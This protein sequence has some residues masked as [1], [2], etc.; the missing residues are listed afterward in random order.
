MEAYDTL[1]EA[2]N[3]LKKQGYT[4]DFNLLEDCLEC[5]NGKHKLT[6]NEFKVDKFFRFEDYMF[7]MSNFDCSISTTHNIGM[8][9]SAIRKTLN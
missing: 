5:R 2:I 1:V 7:N 3:A 6:P 8:S 9:S 4:E